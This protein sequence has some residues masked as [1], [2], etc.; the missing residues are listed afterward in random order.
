MWSDVMQILSGG[1]VERRQARHIARTAEAASTFGGVVRRPMGPWRLGRVT[2]SAPVPHR[3]EPIFQE[4][5]AVLRL[6]TG[7]WRGLG[8]VRPGLLAID[9]AP[10]AKVDPS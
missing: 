8:T 7:A 6:G 9:V 2:G 1:P 5:T 4:V 10:A 3:A